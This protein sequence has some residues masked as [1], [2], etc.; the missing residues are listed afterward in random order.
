MPAEVAAELQAIAAAMAARAEEIV[1]R[2]WARA[3]EHP[4]YAV[5]DEED[6]R[7]S[8]RR[9]V[10][11]AVAVLRGDPRPQERVT[12]DEFATGRRRARQGIP[13]EAMTTLFREVYGVLRDAVVETG[14]AEGVGVEA[15]VTGLQWLWQ[16]A[17]ETATTMLTGYHSAE[18]DQVRA[19]ES[20]RVSFLTALLLGTLP[21]PASA[22]DDVLGYG[23]RRS[24]RYW[25]VRAR[26]GPEEGG[27][28]SRQLLA[29]ARTAGVPD[30]LLG[31]VDDEVVG[32][33]SAPPPADLP[34]GGLVAVDGPGV[35]ADLHDVYGAAGELLAGGLRAGRRGIVDRASLGL[36]L[37]VYDRR[38][39]GEHL[40]ARYIRPLQR[41]RMGRDVLRTLRVHLAH[42]RSVAETARVLTVHPNTVR[43][44]VE[45]FVE[46]TGAD[47]TDTETLAEVWWA[48]EFDNPG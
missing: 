26:V 5:I 10:S 1:S 12:E 42:R 43:Y 38:D 47:L 34:C 23:L 30:P 4:S 9:N 39:V 27:P 19:E 11:R 44:R 46:I 48:L 37:A 41:T 28:L 14:R 13:A 18:L 6:L 25:V 8:G 24:G 31:P 32:V 16:S 2:Q 15:L 45:R 20:R 21:P 36:R 22:D 7:A 29:A 17:D 35:P 33:L 3:Q 40:C